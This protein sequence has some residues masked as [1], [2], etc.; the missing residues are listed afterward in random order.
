MKGLSHLYLGM[1]RG[2]KAIFTGERGEGL[3]PSLLGYGIGLKPSSLRNGG[4]GLKPSLLGTMGRVKAIF[5]W[6]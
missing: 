3:K 2:V 5:T 4:G 1:G 6:E